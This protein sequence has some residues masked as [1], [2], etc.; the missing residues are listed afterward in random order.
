[1]HVNIDFKLII[2]HCD[3]PWKEPV[4]FSLSLEVTPNVIIFDSAN[5]Q[6]D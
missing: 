3:G 5:N 6:T 2:H 4:L 1:M